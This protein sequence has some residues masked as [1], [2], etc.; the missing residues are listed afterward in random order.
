MIQSLIILTC[1]ISLFKTSF[2]FVEIYQIAICLHTSSSITVPNQD[3]R[4][5]CVYVYIFVLYS[6]V[7]YFILYCQMLMYQG[8]QQIKLLL[9]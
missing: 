4:N 5:L 1:N 9:N 8:I 2:D 3:N 6:T 7:M